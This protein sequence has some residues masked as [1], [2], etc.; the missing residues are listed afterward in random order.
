MPIP[1]AFGARRALDLE[2]MSVLY[3]RTARA[4]RAAS[5]L[6]MAVN[7]WQT[8]TTFTTHVE[9]QEPDRTSFDMFIEVSKLYPHDQWAMDSSDLA[10]NARSALDD[11]N[12]RLFKKY[13]TKEYDAKRIQFPITLTGKEWRNWKRSHDALPTWLIERYRQVQPATGPYIGLKGLAMLNNQDKHV[14]LPRASM[15]KTELAGS[16]TGTDAG[17]GDT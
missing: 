6:A 3:A 15:A 16:S 13:A 12:D 10:H 14:W 9:V 2:E 1:S 4:S 17:P 5:K 8:S 11:F 7:V